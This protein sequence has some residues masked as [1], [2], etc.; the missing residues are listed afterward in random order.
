M[1]PSG[2]KHTDITKLKMS[3][4]AK[5]HKNNLGN[6]HSA[7]TRLKIGLG[8]KGKIVSEETKMK[9]SKANKGKHHTEEFKLKLSETMKGNTYM[10]R[11][12]RSDETRKKISEN[13]KGK[14]YCLG[15]KHSNE[16]KLKWSLMRKG[17]NNPN[18]KGGITPEQDKIRHCTET[19]HW[20]KAVYD[21]DKY[22]CQICGAKDK[23][24]NAHHIKPFKDYPEL[25][26]DINNGITL[27]EDCHKDI[28]K[29]HIKTKILLEV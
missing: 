7:E 13:S 24:L 25:R 2:F 15:F 10:V 3:L 27:C 6:H 17:E 5:G 28:H 18:W 1:R 4:A 20:R 12:K 29:S 8:N 19:T 23:Y 26:F 16:T 11:V 21:K 14:A 22:T 9:I